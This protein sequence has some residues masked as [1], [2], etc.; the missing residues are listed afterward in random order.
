[1]GGKVDYLVPDRFRF[2]YGLSVA[3]VNEAIQ[4]FSPDVLVTVDNGIS[5]L[6]GVEEARE[7]GIGVIVTDHH[8]P[9]EKLPEADAVV[10]PHQ[11]GCL[12]PAKNLAGVG[13]I[14]YVVSALRTRLRDRGYFLEKNIPELNMG[15][16]LDLVALGT[17]ADV[18][19]LD[20]V[21]RILVEQ[22]LGRIRAGNTRDGILALARVAK[23]LPQ[24]MLASDFAFAL[25]PRINAAGRLDDMSIGIQCLLSESESEALVL[26]NEL[27]QLNHER[28]QVEGEMKKTAF[29]ILESRNLQASELDWGLCLYDPQW[30]Q[31]VTGLL[32]SR[33]KE[34]FHRPVAVFAPGETS[35]ELKGSCRSIPGFHIRDALDAVATGSPGLIEKFGGHA[36]AAGLSIKEDSFGQFCSA[37]DEVVHAHLD[38]DQLESVIHYDLELEPEH[39][40]LQMA[41]ILRAV[42]PWGQAFP[43]PVFMGFFRVSNIRKLTGNHLKLEV[44]QMDSNSGEVLEEVIEAI[45][46]N[47]EEPLLAD[48]QSGHFVKMCYRLGVN[49]FRGIESLQLIVDYLELSDRS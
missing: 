47:V 14:F 30:H 49:D 21:N 18:V 46:F 37:F 9:G 48:L 5:S 1:M 40:N 27:D 44:T 15:H 6:E 13:V 12:F 25:A 22:G 26:A 39:I 36:M 43:E 34:K 2:G 10:N 16:Y 35:G 38:K 32:A 8:L 11:P 45:F 31:G 41:A 17:V 20:Q 4:M 19:P 7:R 28:K 23:R 33:L 29:A 42:E 24:K 3:I